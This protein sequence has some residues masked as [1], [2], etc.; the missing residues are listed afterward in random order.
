MPLCSH[1]YHMQSKKKLQQELSLTDDEVVV[2]DVAKADLT[3]ALQGCAALIVATSATPKPVWS[4]FPGFFW[5]R[6]VK[7]EKVMPKFTYPA[8][9]KQVCYH[10]SA[11]LDTAVRNGMPSKCKQSAIDVPSCICTLM[12]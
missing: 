7:Q 11:T 4:S 3:K 1:A 9:P 5:A 10:V 2:A 8:M 12:I 6:F